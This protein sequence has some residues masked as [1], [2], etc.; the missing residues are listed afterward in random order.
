MGEQDHQRWRYST[1]IH[2]EQ[3]VYLTIWKDLNKEER[4]EQRNKIKLLKL[5]ELS[6]ACLCTFGAQAVRTQNDIADEYPIYPP[7][8]HPHIFPGYIGDIFKV[9]QM[10]PQLSPRYP[11]G[12]PIIIII[13]IS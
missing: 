7:R 12:I 1:V 8:Y 13:N 5:G 4:K 2:L 11:P 3:S 6:G 9:S 10:Y